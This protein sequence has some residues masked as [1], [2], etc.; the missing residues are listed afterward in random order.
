MSKQKPVLLLVA[1]AAVLAL[2]TLIGLGPRLGA[3]TKKPAATEASAAAAPTL[4]AE[5]L[6]LAVAEVTAAPGDTTLTLPVVLVPVQQ[7]PMIRH[8]EGFV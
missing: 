6:K 5:P 2:F 4:S 3:S 8:A 1:T 7:W